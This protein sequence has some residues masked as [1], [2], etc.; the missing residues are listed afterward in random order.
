VESCRLL[1]KPSATVFAYWVKDPGQ[2]GVVA[3]EMRAKL[4]I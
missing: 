2:Y 3:F 1:F 4:S